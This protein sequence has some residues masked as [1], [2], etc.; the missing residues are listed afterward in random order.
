MKN[1]VHIYWLIPAKPYRE[2]FRA[3]IRVLAKQFDAPR[4]EPHLT[5]FTTAQG[6]RRTKEILR[7]IKSEPIRL[8]VRGIGLSSKFTKTLFIR[9]QSSEALERL[10][11]DLAQISK[12][13]P[14]FVSDPHLSLLYKKMSIPVQRE[15]ARS[16]KLPFS[17]VSFD[18]IKAV[19][20]ASPTLNRA[21]VEAWRVVATKSLAG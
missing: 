4:F 21:D 1:R 15:L 16:I 9:F 20:C 10:I 5:F 8:K 2:L 3:L 18:S 14:R 17:E 13:R 12:S 7:Q 6:R 19:Q 11:V